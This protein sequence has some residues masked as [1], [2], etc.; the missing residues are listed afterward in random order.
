MVTGA[1]RIAHIQ[2]TEC[3]RQPL[4]HVLKHGR[5]LSDG[6]SRQVIEP[7]N[8]LVHS[9]VTG[10][11]PRIPR[12]KSHCPAL[13]CCPRPALLLRKRYRPVRARRAVQCH[14]RT[15]APFENA[16]ANRLAEPGL[17]TSKIGPH[18]G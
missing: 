4:M 13:L 11:G 1:S 7:G 16:T 2:V 10:A 14:A 5:V 8:G 18:G 6:Q 12:W 17:T 15:G 3:L 9:R